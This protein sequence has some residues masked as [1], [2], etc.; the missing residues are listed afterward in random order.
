MK[1]HAPHLATILALALL[2]AACS[3]VPLTGRNQLTLIP[4]G[5][6]LSMSYSSYDQFL[7]ESRVVKNSEDA[8]MVERVGERIS[9]A[10]EQYFNEEGMGDRLEGYEWEFN[11][12]DDDAVNAFCMPGGKVGIFRGILPV[13]E[14]DA[15]LA[16]VM[17]HEIAHAV[18]RHGN[19][20]MSQQ[21]SVALGGVALG[22]AMREKPERTQQLF[23]AAY[24]LGS[25]VGVLLP[26]SRLHESEADRLGL[27][28]MAIAGYN[29]QEAV[30]FWQRMDAQGGGQPPEFL[31]T[32]PSHDTRIEKIRE[33]MDEAMGYYRG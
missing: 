18:A 27:I 8:A 13:A 22:V 10:V 1:R 25:Q 5:Q 14:D 20:R 3:S 17:S 7:Q 29:P 30:G 15:G 2:L 28:F 32:H 19:E 26:Y 21:L 24:G 23:Y 9:D 31:S 16:V 4:T 11:L 6:M 33:H 12:I